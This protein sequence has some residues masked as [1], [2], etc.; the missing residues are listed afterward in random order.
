MTGKMIHIPE[1]IP[2]FRH[3]TLIFCFGHNL[4]R[5]FYVHGREMEEMEMI[6]T[7]DTEYEYSDKEGFNHAGP[8]GGSSPGA[9][10]HNREHYD[11]VFLNYF[12]EQLNDIEKKYDFD[13]IVTLQPVDMKGLNKEKW[14][15]HLLPKTEFIAGNFHNHPPLDILHKILK[16]SSLLFESKIA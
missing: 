12:L 6:H 14:P 11:H 2:K 10:K 16:E 1:E 8:G 4:A 7:E 3:K 15:K 9:D 13:Q 5:P